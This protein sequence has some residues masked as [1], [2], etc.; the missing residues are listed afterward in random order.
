[1]TMTFEEIEKCISATDPSGI[2]VNALDGSINTT[3]QWLHN[4][5]QTF[6]AAA[7]KKQGPYALTAGE[8]EALTKAVTSGFG[9]LIKECVYIRDGIEAPF[10]NEDLVKYVE[11]LLHQTLADVLR[12]MQPR[13][14]AS[15]AHNKDGDNGDE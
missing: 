7:I 13:I 12:V 5:A 15:T 6:E 10:S 14:I 2:D 8:E 9:A 4:F 11:R 1:M 3:A